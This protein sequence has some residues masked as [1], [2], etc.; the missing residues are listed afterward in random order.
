MEP[1]LG[2]SVAR[3]TPAP[4]SDSALRLRATCILSALGLATVGVL[5]LA[6]L[7]GRHWPAFVSPTVL[8][9][10]FGLRHAVDA[11]HIAAIDNVSRKLISEGQRPLCVGLF[12]SLGHSS[13]VVLLCAGVAAGSSCLR[14][15]LGSLA[16]MGAIVGTSVSAAVLLL[17]AFVNLNVA[18]AL[19]GQW[20][21]VL[22]TDQDFLFDNHDRPDL[23]GYHTHLFS[24]DSQ[25]A[26]RPSGSATAQ[27]LAGLMTSCG[28]CRRLLAA[29]DASWKMY[30]VGF[31]F[32][33]GFDTASEVG[34]LALAAM[35]GQQGVPAAVV[36]LLPLAFATGM[37]LVDTLDG[38]LM[39]WAYSWAMLHPARRLGFNLYLT[40]ISALIALLVA[41]VEV[42]GCL[43]TELGL[44][45][46]LWDAVQVVNDHFEY[47]GYG[48][49]SLFALST[50]LAVVL[51][52]RCFAPAAGAA[53]AG[54]KPQVAV[55]DSGA[56]AVSSAN[57]DDYVKS[58]LLAMARGEVPVRAIE[59]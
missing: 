36:M 58:R 28:C 55:A 23:P 16:D 10:T 3:S 52:D 21:S 44:Q 15:R 54:S 35:G 48:I 13:V 31:L 42:L 47:V 8:A 5:T 1:L 17:V 12:F 7:V 4:Q 2:A 37:S 27:G 45:G 40:S 18:A 41:L 9:F 32:G 49:M 39:L 6:A 38:M 57:V 50:L 19:F 24:V 53:E 11:D 56:E 59:I 26:L 34:L 46:G 14:E 33:L 20:R 22:R 51:L 25:A 29:V 43:Q 30:P